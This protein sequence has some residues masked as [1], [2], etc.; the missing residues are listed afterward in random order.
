MNGRIVYVDRVQKIKKGEKVL[1]TKSARTSGHQSATTSDRRMKIIHLK[2]EAELQGLG[3]TYLRG[4]VKSNIESLKITSTEATE[5]VLAVW[6]SDQIRDGFV[7]RDLSPKIFTPCLNGVQVVLAVLIYRRAKKTIK[8]SG[9]T[10][11]KIL[12]ASC[13]H[14]AI[15]MGRRLLNS[16]G[17]SLARLDH[18]YF[19][20]A[21]TL[22]LNGEAD[23]FVSGKKVTEKK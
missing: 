22:V 17:I 5:A 1:A 20:S 8:S 2:L 7:D 9:Q 12:N 16:L 11:N 6:C 4:C 13:A 15:R 18:S 10:K 21:K 19:N 3:Y 14:I 23:F